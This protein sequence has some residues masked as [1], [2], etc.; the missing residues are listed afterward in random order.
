MAADTLRDYPT[1][2]ILVHQARNGRVD[3]SPKKKFWAKSYGESELFVGDVITITISRETDGPYVG[4]VF[5]TER[6]AVVEIKESDFRWGNEWI[7]YFER[8]D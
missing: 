3:P 4:R 1:G 8:L 5:M 7:T 6:W 2:K